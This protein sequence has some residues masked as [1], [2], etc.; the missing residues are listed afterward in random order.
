MKK[1]EY[2]SKIEAI[3]K[4]A[5]EYERAEFGYRFNG[6]PITIILDKEIEDMDSF[7]KDF[8]SSRQPFRLWGVRKRLDKN[9]YRV[10]SIDLHTGH[11]LNMEVTPEWI[12]IYLPKGSC[13]NTIYRLFTNVQQYYDSEAKLNIWETVYSLQ[14]NRTDC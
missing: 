1:K 3:E 14:E 10:N 2:A 5:I 7:L 8:F 4:N 6:Q 13:G 11:K 12:R 9:F